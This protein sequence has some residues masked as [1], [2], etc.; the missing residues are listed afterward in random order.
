MHKYS[1]NICEHFVIHSYKH[2]RINS[3]E[4][5]QLNYTEVHLYYDHVPKELVPPST[6]LRTKWVFMTAIAHNKTDAYNAY[7]EGI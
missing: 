1:Y 6:S 3:P 4:T 2:G 5:D 7:K